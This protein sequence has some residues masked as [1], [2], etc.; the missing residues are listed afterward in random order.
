[1]LDLAR[2]TT[3]FSRW[4]PSLRWRPDLY[5]SLPRADYADAQVHRGLTLLQDELWLL[6][7][8]LGGLEAYRDFKFLMEHI[9][10]D[11]GDGSQPSGYS[12]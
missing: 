3:L 6:E 12:R 5:S 8:R 10:R 11:F 1:M 9:T 4:A 7:D 2:W